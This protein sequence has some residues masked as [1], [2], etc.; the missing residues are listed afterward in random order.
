MFIQGGRGKGGEQKKNPGAGGGGG[1]VC[2]GGGGG[3]GVYIMHR[4]GNTDDCC[5]LVHMS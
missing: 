2:W 4:I 5:S 1:G 3:G